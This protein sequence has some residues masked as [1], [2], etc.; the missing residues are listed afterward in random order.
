MTT[1]QRAGVPRQLT[2]AIWRGGCPTAY[3]IDGRIDERMNIGGVKVMPNLLEDAA[4]ACRG[5]LDACRLRAPRQ[6]RPG[7]A[8]DSRRGAAG[9]HPRD[10]DDLA[11]AEC[12]RRA[13]R[14]A[15]RVERGNPAAPW[16]TRSS[17]RPCDRCRSRAALTSPT[18]LKRRVDSACLSYH[19]RV[20]PRALAL[21]SSPAG[22][23]PTPKL[24]A[25]VSR[26]TPRPARP[27]RRPRRRPRR[28]RRRSTRFHRLPCDDPWR[29]NA[30]PW[31]ARPGPTGA[32]RA[33]RSAS[34]RQRNGRAH[35][36][37]RGLDTPS[38]AAASRRSPVARRR[39]RPRRHRPRAADLRKHGQ[40]PR[41][42][43]RS[44]AGARGAAPPRRSPSSAL[45]RSGP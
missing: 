2:W 27:G 4:L 9:D 19:A 26:S 10:A 40:A 25:D 7:R 23:S 37:L 1:S 18:R 13:A 31:P 29:W 34:A 36:A 39:A 28:R 5:V 33:W 32:E 35:R 6:A 20:R 16:A 21:R 43:G 11:S 45:D 15:H 22:E 8:L 14:H 41:R 3:V 24:D 42:I 44:S 17:E 12:P 30:S 38:R